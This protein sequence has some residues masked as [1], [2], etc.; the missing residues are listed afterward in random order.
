MFVIILG[1]PLILL[2]IILGI[3]VGSRLAEKITK[4]YKLFCETPQS[5]NYVG[6]LTDIIG[7]FWATMGAIAGAIIKYNITFPQCVSGAINGNISSGVCDYISLVN[8]FEFAFIG[9]GIGALIGLVMNINL[10]KLLK[11]LKKK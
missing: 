7:I 11:S 1:I 2:T 9:V 8:S 4:S 5:I 10:L 3:I 6:C